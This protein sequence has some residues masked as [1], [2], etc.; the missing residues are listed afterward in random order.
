MLKCLR[1]LQRAREQLVRCQ[2][3]ANRLYTF[4][5]DEHDVFTRVLGNLPCGLPLRSAIADFVER[6]INVNMRHLVRLK[7]IAKHPSFP[8]ELKCGRHKD[9]VISN[10]EDVPPDD[11][12]RT[13][14]DR[15]PGDEHPAHDVEH[16]LP[17]HCDTHNAPDVDDFVSPE[18]EDED[19]EGDVGGIIDFV[20]A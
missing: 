8:G 19:I 16:V 12:P 18:D 15:G 5:L 13:C 4:I 3:E 17:S 1:R 14:G 7:Q 9:S 10:G 2:V 6:R 11:A 20:A